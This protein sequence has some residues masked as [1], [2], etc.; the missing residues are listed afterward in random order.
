MS[1]PSIVR[2][3]GAAFVLAVVVAGC[4]S[5]DQSPLS[6]SSSQAAMDASP[7]AGSVASVAGPLHEELRT[8]LEGRLAGTKTAPMASGRARWEE[9][10]DRRK[11]NTQ[12]EDL[13]ASGAYGVKVNGVSVATVTVSSG[14]GE[15]ELDSRRGDTVPVMHVGDMVEVLNPAGD[16]VVR[17]VLAGR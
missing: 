16:V 13:T 1:T 14:R 4:S 11:F 9:R 7:S 12:V 2:A 3:A 5:N 8:R 6:A 17:G 10:P 15:V